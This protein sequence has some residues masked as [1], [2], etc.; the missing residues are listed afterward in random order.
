MNDL[1]QSL[2]SSIISPTLLIWFGAV[3]GVSFV[4]TPA[5]FL[6]PELDLE[7]AI[8]IGRATF[9]VFFYLECFLAGLLALQLALCDN[10]R[11]TLIYISTLLALFTIQQGVIAPLVQANSDNLLLGNTGYSN[12]PHLVFIFTEI[13]KSIM[14]VAYSPALHWSSNRTIVLENSLQADSN[15]V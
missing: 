2:G 15:H 3:I 6:I 5:K 4:A 1:K 11:F 9:S 8:K 13:V 14:L 7:I 10:T 12:N